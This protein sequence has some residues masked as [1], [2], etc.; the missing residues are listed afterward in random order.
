MAAYLILCY[1]SSQKVF[2][3]ICRAFATYEEGVEVATEEK[4]EKHTHTHTHTHQE[5]ILWNSYQSKLK[6]QSE[7]IPDPLGW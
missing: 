4:K 3:F 6:V 2:H 1:K 7:L 5:R